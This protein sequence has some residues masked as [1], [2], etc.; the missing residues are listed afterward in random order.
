MA[1]VPQR[2]V[3]AVL[4]SAH[5]RPC[6]EPGAVRMGTSWDRRYNPAYP[7][8]GWLLLSS[9]KWSVSCNCYCDPGGLL[10]LKVFCCI[11]L[12][13]QRTHLSLYL[14]ILI[15]VVCSAVIFLVIFLIIC[16]RKPKDGEWNVLETL[17]VLCM[18]S[19]VLPLRALG[20]GWY[21][22][23]GYLQQLWH[24]YHPGTLSKHAWVKIGGGRSKEAEKPLSPQGKP[25][26]AVGEALQGAP[27]PREGLAPW[28]S[29][30]CTAPPCA[31][32]RG[33]LSLCPTPAILQCSASPPRCPL[34]CHDYWGTTVSLWFS[35]TSRG[36]QT[37]LLDSVCW[38]NLSGYLVAS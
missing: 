1:A 22:A 5:K 6:S 19:L 38:S 14:V 31:G 2:D 20:A 17:N 23:R 33:D 28:W 34:L 9:G 36:S 12:G 16:I 37:Y 24:L 13:F 32:S 27:P 15:A 8:Q 3:C 11:A 4:S 35:Q 18:P 10:C 30:V 21:C 7:P 26:T 29:S 25:V